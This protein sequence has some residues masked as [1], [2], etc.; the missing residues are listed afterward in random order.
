MVSSQ[1]QIQTNIEPY[2]QLET[3]ASA[4]NDTYVR[5]ERA[6]V[7][8]VKEAVA[9][10]LFSEAKLHAT[11][12]EYCPNLSKGVRHEI[13]GLIQKLAFL[14]NS[15]RDAF[16][17]LNTTNKRPSIKTLVQ[18]LR[19]ATETGNTRTT[20]SEAERWNTKVIRFLREAVR[21]PSLLNCKTKEQA[22]AE[23]GES[24]AAK[25]WDQAESAEIENEQI[26]KRRMESRK[27]YFGAT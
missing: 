2:T 10:E 19:M 12:D 4:I 7:A 5:A 16:L 22:S 17:K 11:F 15:D 25:L 3:S 1:T 13:I 18:E 23:W 20:R 26:N 9:G 24:I 27:Q 21:D 14:N 6:K 8:F